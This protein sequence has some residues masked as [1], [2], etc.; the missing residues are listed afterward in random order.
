MRSLNGQIETAF[1]FRVSSA[2]TLQWVLDRLLVDTVSNC[3]PS[4]VG[5]RYWSVTT[6]GHVKS[7]E[8]L[9]HARG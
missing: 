2:Q 3:V 5:F 1:P 8:V 6:H 4:T 9:L 7:T